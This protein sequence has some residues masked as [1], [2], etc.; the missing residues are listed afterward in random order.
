MSASA[1]GSVIE[2]TKA[3][4]AAVVAAQLEDLLDDRAVLAL[5]LARAAGRR[6]SRRG[7]PRPRRAGG[8]AASLSAA[9]ATPRCRPF[10][11]T[12]RTPPGSRTRSATSATVP[13]VAYSFSCRG[14]SSTRSSS[15]TSTVRVTV[16]FGKTTVSS[17]GIS[18]SFGNAT[19]FLSTNEMSCNCKKYSCYVPAHQIAVTR[20]GDGRETAVESGLAMR[21]RRV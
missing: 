18:R 1:P 17:S 2:R 14:T 19:H 7:A 15:P 13:T 21:E 11:A 12:A 9:P 8:P 16:M 3:R 5:E 20:A 10:S 4:D 6:A